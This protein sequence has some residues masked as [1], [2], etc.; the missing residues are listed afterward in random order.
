MFLKKHTEAHVNSTPEKIWEYASSPKHWS[1]SNKEEH[2]GLEIYSESGK[3]ETNA[4]FHQRETVAGIYADLRGHFPIVN[5]PN[6]TVWTGIARYKILGGL[7]YVEIPEG[8]LVKVAVTEQGCIISH[9]V[10]MQFSDSIKGKVIHWV[11]TNIFKG[12]DA[13]YSHTQ[14]ELDYFKEKLEGENL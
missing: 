12:E 4:E 2:L 5:K 9:D 11:F 1:D 14:K 7:F 6:L 8:G 13:V 3:P 10:W